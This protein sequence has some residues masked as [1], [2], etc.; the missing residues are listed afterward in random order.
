MYRHDVLASLV[1]KKTHVIC[2]EEEERRK[3]KGRVRESAQVR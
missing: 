2:D 1:K 3:E